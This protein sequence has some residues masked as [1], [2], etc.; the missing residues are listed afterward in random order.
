[1]GLFNSR[2]IYNKQYTI[3][4]TKLGVINIYMEGDFV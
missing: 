2:Y 3:N 1:M 4:F